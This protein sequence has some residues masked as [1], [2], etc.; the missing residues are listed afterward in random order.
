M[1]ETYLITMEWLPFCF[2]PVSGKAVTISDTVFVCGCEVAE[3]V[4]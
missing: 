1:A 3:P 4:V 2:V